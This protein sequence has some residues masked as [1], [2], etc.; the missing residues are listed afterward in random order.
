MSEGKKNAG[1]L[2]LERRKGGAMALLEAR[3][4]RRREADPGVIKAVLERQARGRTS[5]RPKLRMIHH[6][7]CTGGT[8]ISRGLQ[9]QPNAVV[10]SEVDPLSSIQI[11]TQRSRFAPT[12]PI[13]LARAGLG[14]IGNDVAV[15]MFRASVEVLRARLDRQGRRLVLR[16][17]PHSHFCTDANWDERPTVSEMFE[18]ELDILSV[19]TVRH[20]LD[21]WLALDHNEWRHFQPFSLEEY[22]RRYLAFLD[23]HAELPLFRYEAFVSDPDSEMRRLCDALDMQFNSDWQSLISIINLSG[24]SGRRSDQ[25]SP[26]ARRDV[27][28]AVKREAAESQTFLELCDRLNYNVNHV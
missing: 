21:S 16:S 20:P 28:G 10:L 22:A 2:Q 9:A 3:Y 6:M 18:G 12:D 5:K 4:G 25:I 11:R 13:L 1:L 26:R 24:D 15:E 17:H 8:L 19:L 23:R 7:A 14:S 27:T